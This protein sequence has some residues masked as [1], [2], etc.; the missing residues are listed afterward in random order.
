MA[1]AA[2]AQDIRRGARLQAAAI[3][4]DGTAPPRT[5]S[6]PNPASPPHFEA[7][8]SRTAGHAP[9]SSPPDPPATLEDL[10]TE[11]LMAIAAFLPLSDIAS[12][13]CSC[14]RLRDAA[15]LLAESWAAANPHQRRPMLLLSAPAT[16]VAPARDSSDDAA[17]AAEASGQWLWGRA[18]A[19]LRMSLPHDVTTMQLLGD[20]SMHVVCGLD[21][22][23]LAILPSDMAGGFGDPACHLLSSSPGSGAAASNLSRA[24]LAL[25]AAPVCAEQAQLLVP[26]T[27]GDTAPPPPSTARLQALAAA[28]CPLFVVASVRADGRGD[29]WLCGVGGGHRALE[30]AAAFVSDEAAIGVREVVCVK[31]LPSPASAAATLEVL[32]AQRDRLTIVG[33]AAGGRCEAVRVLPLGDSLLVWSMAVSPEHNLA[34]VGL[35]PDRV[36]IWDLAAMRSQQQQ[37]PHPRAVIGVPAAP[38]ALAFAP[39]SAAAA[40]NPVLLMGDNTGVC[41]LRLDLRAQALGLE[42]AAGGDARSC[43]QPVLYS[44]FVPPPGAGLRLGCLYTSLS[45]AFTDAAVGL[46]CAMTIGGRLDIMRVHVLAGS[47]ADASG[48]VQCRLRLRR[49]LS[50]SIAGHKAPPRP[51]AAVLR[52]DHRGL[53]MLAGGHMASVPA[54]P[55][56]YAPSAVCLL[57]LAAGSL[58]LAPAPA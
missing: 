58:A 23:G 21:S 20:A 49:C 50:V 3:R 54:A 32:V 45:L 24:V 47:A 14:R 7:L 1:A 53:V 29:I 22:G 39:P 16:T 42:S 46:A 5:T 34:A 10:P 2:G 35:L 57:E 25:D 18:A 6:P 17:A 4:V 51:V 8:P 52:P 27:D 15:P 40:S 11:M 41:A 26:G 9:R 55:D 43:D 13:R 31:M 28:G 37:Q 56:A 44:R 12:L 33:L 48:E 36:Q 30:H 38:S 19:A